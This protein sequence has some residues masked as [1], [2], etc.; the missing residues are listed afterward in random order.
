MLVPGLVAVLAV[1]FGLLLGLASDRASP[2]VGALRT[3]AFVAAL[4]V[5]LTH[6]LP[7]ALAELGAPGVL[8]FAATAVVPGWMRLLT[9]A[10]ANHSGGSGHA[11]LSAGYAGLVVHHVGDG[12]GLGAY[13]ELPGGPFAHADVLLALAVHT[14]PLVAVVAMAFRA[15]GGTRAAFT[16]AAGLAAASVGGVVLSGAVPE[17]LVHSL[18]AWIAAGVAG[19]LLHVVTHDLG[20]DLPATPAARV[21]D[22]A[23]AAVGV[24]ASMV[25]GDPE[26]AALRSELWRVLRE[27]LGLAA[28]AVVLAWLIAL[29]LARLDG[30]VAR[31]LA[32][33]PG[34]TRGLDG[35]LV[36]TAVA[37]PRFGLLFWVGTALA[38]RLI[39]LRPS[40]DSPAHQHSPDVDS[41]PPDDH[42]P[43]AH[44]HSP[45]DH[46]IHPHD[47]SPHSHGEIPVDVDAG[48]SR[49]HR[50]LVGCVRESAP[51]VIVGV[52]LA[53]LLVAAPR[54]DAFAG[55][56]AWLALLGVT[57]VA[58][59]L[60]FPAVAAV[61]VAVALWDRGLRPDAALAFALMASAPKPNR[62]ALALVLLVGLGVGSVNARSAVYV[63]LPAAVSLAGLV[64]VS[65][66][67]AV[68][69]WRRGIRGLFT[70]VFHSHDT[71]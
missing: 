9:G 56:S 28:P 4:A 1:G 55:L 67:V 10:S 22:L 6:L 7:E 70:A 41:H 23:A 3:A 62:R 16:R 64:L 11:A 71:A 35:A 53:T 21:L 31:W 49:H 26:L 24:A 52:V 27:L 63:Q 36:G 13:S 69:A 8:L 60:E 47:H 44:D 59:P 43:H 38:S 14:V 37:G 12:L 65:L 54:E 58:L 51:W 42:S 46:A 50:G 20:R 45:H 57:A 18:S 5:A 19:L 30:P 29:L 66:G 32:V 15:V 61:L 48:S 40:T 39:A 2:G 33:I 68:A 17:R 25:G 34:R